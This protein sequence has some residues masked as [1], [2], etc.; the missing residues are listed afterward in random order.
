GGQSFFGSHSRCL[1]QS[2]AGHE[3]GAVERFIGTA[4]R[5]GSH[6]ANGGS[7]GERAE[8]SP[9]DTRYR[10]TAA[11][12]LHGGNG[13]QCYD[14]TLQISPGPGSACAG[15]DCAAAIRRFWRAVSVAGEVM[16]R[17]EQ[18]VG[19]QSF[20]RAYGGSG[21]RVSGTGGLEFE[22]GSQSGVVAELR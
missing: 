20:A 4:G 15:R 22:G 1:H 5:R 13:S 6:N 10:T 14:T 21:S 18:T 16:R 7:D 12:A 2:L 17:G 3:R 8:V 9:P 19:K 11:G